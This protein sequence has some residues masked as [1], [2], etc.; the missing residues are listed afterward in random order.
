MMFILLALLSISPYFF[1]AC[2]TKSASQEPVV[3]GQD[4]SWCWFQD[5]RA[6]ISGNQLI[7]GA[8][9]HGRYDS[10]LTG[11]IEGF[12]Y[13]LKTGKITRVELYNHLEADDHTS[14]VFLKRPDN[15]WLTLF[16]KHGSENHFYYRISEPDN[17]TDWNPIQRYIP[18][19]STK[20]TYSNIYLL[21][22]ENNRI[23]DFFR[24]LDDTY[25]PS[26]V[27]SD[28]LGKTWTT[29]NVYI[30]VPA[31]QRHRPYVRYA[32]NGVDEIH[33]LY[34]EGHPRVYD[35][36][37]YHIYYSNGQL[38]HSDGTVLRSLKDGLHR[39]Q[40]GTM[41]FQ[42]DSDHVAWTVDLELDDQGNP[43]AVYSVQVGSAGLPV[44]QGG[45]DIRYR[46]A[47]WDGQEWHDYPLAYAGT[48]LYSGEDDYSGLVALDPDDPDVLYISTNADPVSG[49]PLISDADSKRH[50]E[51]FKGVTSSRGADW[52]WTPITE[53]STQDNIRP[54]VPKWNKNRTFLLWLRGEY[55]AYTD[56]SMEILGLDVSPGK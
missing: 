50:Y 44:G 46:Y 25:K 14:P 12:V 31:K 30:D 18:S 6:F 4:G 15:R 56:F 8:T 37:I 49:D 29:G 2:S 54:I 40:E 53:N 17:P 32:S 5:P 28:D 16:A 21:S 51:I 55:R 48:K 23:Y 38:H 1:V 7:V 24:G 20:L 52:Q 3:I 43:Y 36:S 13:N 35:N 39:P 41:V 45:E 27:Y 22:G 33:M 26:Y 10:L 11:D 42:G 34:T 47:R 9:A 19:E